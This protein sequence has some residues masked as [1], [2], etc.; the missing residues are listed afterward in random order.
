MITT[1]AGIPAWIKVHKITHQKPL[2]PLADSDMDC[3]GYVEI[4][5][6]VCDSNKRHASWLERKLTES[7]KERITNE[8]LENLNEKYDRLG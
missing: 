8:I 5:Y 3:Y 2:G 7:D 1:I 4:D 6:Q